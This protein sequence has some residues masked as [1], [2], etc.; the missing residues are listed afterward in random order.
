MTSSTIIDP[1][2]LTE[3]ALIRHAVE[4]WKK[5][6]SDQ[7]K[8]IHT[9]KAFTADINLFASFLP[10]DHTIKQVSTNEINN[11]LAWL[12]SGRGVPCSPKTLSR[13]ITS[14]K[15]FFRWLHQFGTLTYDPA[16]KVVQKSVLSPLPPIMNSKEVEDALA[17]ASGK[18]SG[19]KPDTRPYLLLKLLLETGIK[20]GELLT[21]SPNHIDTL[22]PENPFIFIRYSNPDYRYKERKIPLSQDWM[23]AYQEYLSQYQIKDKLFPWSPRRL[24]YILEDIGKGIGMVYQLSFLMCRWN[25]ALL[26]YENK[27]ELNKIRQ[28]LG[29]SAIQFREIKNKLLKLVPKYRKI[30]IPPLSKS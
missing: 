24:E 23:D 5:Y 10:P 17:W 15:S 14:L 28:K 4:L 11:F 22:N 21:L 12:Q 2:N 6:L 26:D 27:V 13:R 20:K 18:R 9:I 3:N 1:D 8:S 25:C 30:P 29:I 16:I 7:N 19:D